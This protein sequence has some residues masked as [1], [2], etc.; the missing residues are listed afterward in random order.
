MLFDCFLMFSGS[1][2]SHPECSGL[3]QVLMDMFDLV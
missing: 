2:A 3:I 1:G